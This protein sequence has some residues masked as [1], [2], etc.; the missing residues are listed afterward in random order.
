MTR[1]RLLA[2]FVL[3]TGFA[4]TAPAADVKPVDVLKGHHEPVQG[5][6]FTRDGDHVVSVAYKEIILW[7]L[8]DRAKSLV[9]T[10]FQP[11]EYA[12]GTPRIS[13]DGRFVAVG[14][15]YY[16]NS[17]TITYPC[18][19]RLF[20]IGERDRFDK[21]TY[22]KIL[23]HGEVGVTAADDYEHDTFSEIAF[24]PASLRLAA[25]RYNAVKK[26][27]VLGLYDGDSRQTNN[28]AVY[29]SDSPLKIVY[30]P[31][32]NTLVSADA[33]GK[34]ILWKT[35]NAT[36]R[37]SH[38]VGKGAINDLAVSPNSKTLATAG[39]DKTVRLWDLDKGEEKHALAGHT[40]AVLC[41]AYSRDGK[42]LASG[43]KD[44]NVKLWDPA[45]GKELATIEAHLN[46]VAC[47]AF[48]PDGKYLVTGGADREIRL[49]DVAQ[50][51]KA[52]PDK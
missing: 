8:N 21:F 9:F 33:K 26:K 39:D 14:G 42:Y 34:V 12:W 3:G 27:Y 47:L 4:L 17:N 2:A 25:V 11:N 45:T 1:T 29:T 31:D 18:S 46:S 50:A 35:T 23:P 37:A 44:H 19:I 16:V 49:W 43:G 40:E 41:V 10:G 7:D 6:A 28:D 22:D 32:G 20:E 15:T 5:V 36:Q 38:E 52:K 51:L 24:A 30:T 13:A 48:S